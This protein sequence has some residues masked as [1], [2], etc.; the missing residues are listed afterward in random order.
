M[1]KFDLDKALQGEPVLLR[2]NFFAYIIGIV[3][4]GLLTKLK[5]PSK[6]FPM[7]G[8]IID[9]MDNT[10]IRNYVTW[11]LD[12]KYPSYYNDEHSFDII[13]MYTENKPL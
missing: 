9:P 8:S 4:N 10:V 12:G 1:E 2:N 5:N 6:D 13:G 11:A 7:I 3:P